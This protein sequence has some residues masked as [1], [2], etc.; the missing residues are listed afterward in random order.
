MSQFVRRSS[1]VSSDMLLKVRWQEEPLIMFF[2]VKATLGQ[3]NVSV[4]RVVQ[5]IFNAGGEGGG[6]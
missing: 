2:F 6:K 4:L 5:F 3:L 1:G